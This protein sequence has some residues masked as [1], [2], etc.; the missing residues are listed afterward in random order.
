MQQQVKSSLIFNEEEKEE[1]AQC[2]WKYHDYMKE[3]LDQVSYLLF[4]TT[5]LS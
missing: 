2:S 1:T 4:T 3:I 5:K